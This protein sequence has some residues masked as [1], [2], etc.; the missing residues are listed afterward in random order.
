[1]WRATL[2]VEAISD[3]VVEGFLRFLVSLDR[4]YLAQHPGTP[5]VFRAGVVYRR[6]PKG[7]EFWKT[8]PRVLDD[9]HGD[10]EDLAA[11]RAAELNNAGERARAILRKRQRGDGSWLYHVVVERADGTHEDPSMILGMKG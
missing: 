3:E 9:G 1:M 2:E 7:Q 6:E 5:S 8:I 4:A 10:C 11:W